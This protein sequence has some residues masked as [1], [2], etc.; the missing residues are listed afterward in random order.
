MNSL[1][2]KQKVEPKGLF[3]EVLLRMTG[4]VAGLIRWRSMLDHCGGVV[5]V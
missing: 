4:R 5:D 2:P 1:W 3:S